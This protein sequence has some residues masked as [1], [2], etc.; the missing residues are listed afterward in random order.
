MDYCCSKGI[1]GDR[2]ICD[3]DQTPDLSQ[4]PP[5][6]I[7]SVDA[8]LM[9]IIAKDVLFYE[10]NLRKIYLHIVLKI[11]FTKIL[12]SHPMTIPTLLMLFNSHSLSNKTPVKIPHKVL[13]KSTTIVAELAVYINTPNWDRPTICYDNDDDDEDYAIA[14]TPS[15]STEEPDNSL[16]IGDE[17]L[18]TVP[19][20]E[21]DEF[22][23]SSVESLVLIPS[24][25]EGIPNNMCDVPFHENSPPLDVS[26]D[27]FEDF[28]NSND[29]STLIDEDSFSINNIEYVE[30]SP[31]NSELL[32]SEVMEIVI[33]KVGGIDDDILLTIK[34][35]ILPKKLLSVNLLI[36]NIEAL[37]DNPTPSS[38][39]MTKSDFY[40]FADALAHIISLPEYDCFC[41]KIEPNSGDF[42]MDVVEDIYLTRKPSV[43]NALPTHRTLQLNRDFI[44][45]S[46]SLFTYVKIVRICFGDEILI[47]QGDRSDKGKKST[48]NIISCTKTRKYMGKRCQVFLA[49]VTKKE[50]EV[51]SKEKRLEDVSIERKFLEVFPEDLTGLLPARQVEFQIDLVPGAASVARSPYRLA[52]SEMQELSV[53]LVRDEDIP[54]TA[55]RTRYGHY[56]FQVMPFGLT[57]EPTIFMDLIN[58]VCKTL[59]DKFVIVF[60]D[61]ILIYSRNKVEHE[62]NPK[63]I[64]ELLKK[65]KLYAKFSKCDFGFL[66]DWASPNT[67]TKI[68]QFLGLVGYYR[69]F[70]EGFSKIAK[71]MTKLTQKSVKFDW[72]E[73]E[74]A[75]FQT[76]KQKLCS[77]QIL[78]LRK[79]SENFMVYG[80]ASHKGLGAVLMQ[81]ERVIA[82]ASRQ[83]KIYEKNYTTHD[84]E[85]GAM[86][87]A[88]KMWRHYLY[89]TKC[90][91]FTDN[92]SLQHILDQ[93]E[94]NMRQRRWKLIMH[95]SYKSKYS[96]HPGSDKMYQDLKKLYWWPNMKAEISTYVTLGTQLDISMAYHPQTDGQSERTIQTLKDILRACVIDFKKGWDRH[97]PLVEFSY[98]NSY[99]TSTKS[100]PFEALY[101]RKFRSPICWAK[102]G[103]MIILKESPR[104]RGDTFRQTRKL[105]PRYIRPVKVL[106]KIGTVTYRLE[107][108]DQLS[109]VHSTFHVYNLKK[110]YADEPLAILLDKIQIDD[111]LNF[112]EA[113]VE[114]MDREVKQLKQSRILI[115]KE[116]YSADECYKLKG[117]PIG[118]PL[119][120]IY[121]PPVTGSVNV[122]DNRNPKVNFVGHDAASTSNQAKAS[123]IKDQN[124][125]KAMDLELAA[126]EANH[127]WTITELP[128]GNNNHPINQ[129]KHQLHKE[130]SIKD[131]GTLNYYLGIQILRNSTGLIMTQRKYTLKLLQ[132]AGF[133]NVKPL[134]IPFDH[135]IKVNHDDGELLDDPSQYRTLVGKLLYL[136]ITRPKLLT[137]KSSSSVVNSVDKMS[138]FGGE[139]VVVVNNFIGME[140]CPVECLVCGVGDCVLSVCI[141]DVGV[142]V[143][144]LGDSAGVVGVIEG[145]FE[146]TVSSKVVG[147]DAGEFKGVFVI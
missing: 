31:P 126:L 131:L 85:L 43:H 87:F 30:A 13:H 98:N 111:K 47:I 8:R 15:L 128:Y 105:N 60:I 64:L 17:H 77:A 14:V 1:P 119:H 137:S 94:L 66:R 114:I 139:N 38:D 72:G 73:K 135:I 147:G 9:V 71:P 26:K 24:K 36:A 39:L 35:D 95:E 6:T 140:C 86:V 75:A 138:I 50:T 145:G 41:F 67:L 142:L 110:C 116:G 78:V 93:K 40:E 83:L 125:I 74:V 21:S 88:L 104:K 54:K 127:T 20:T 37:N 100:A 136:T 45:S 117:Y 46:E 129:V 34:D 7:L 70:I 124:W 97:L 76:L 68:R 103:D 28:S 141:G 62:E 146:F 22:I 121:K 12:P 112:I 132:S 118:H 27:Q 59:L 52:P 69:R 108:P 80:D 65:E 133:L 29:G 120:G 58:R 89:D 115:V 56:E 55:F 61:D 44:L 49:Q 11:E 53:Q 5:G 10:R 84:L 79:G 90:V 4:Q 107:L 143:E 106:A 19:T 96:I 23:K 99:H 102:V 122:N 16:S 63:Q 42:T 101:D 51:K 134:S 81:K 3:L 48:L 144:V 33:P 18:N 113:P 32:S 92:K 109:Q 91:A 57:N 2:I 82:Y 130:F 123:T 25:S